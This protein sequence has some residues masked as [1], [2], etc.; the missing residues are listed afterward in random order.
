[1]MSCVYPKF[2]NSGPRNA[3]NTQNMKVLLAFPISLN[4]AWLENALN[5]YLPWKSVPSVG[6][7]FPFR[8]YGLSHCSIRTTLAGAMAGS[9]TYTVPAGR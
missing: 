7:H 5:P 9:V 6:I 3:R 4:G 2:R 8:V 1:M